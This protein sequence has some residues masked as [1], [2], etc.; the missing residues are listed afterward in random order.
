MADVALECTKVM[1]SDCSACSIVCVLTQPFICAV[2]SIVTSFA[3]AASVIV[4]SMQETW[5]YMSSWACLQQIT[6]CIERHDGHSIQS[7]QQSAD[8]E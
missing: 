7:G 5:D 2:A 1:L 3:A 6:F 4:Q 8:S